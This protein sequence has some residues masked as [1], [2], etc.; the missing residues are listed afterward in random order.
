MGGEVKTDTNEE[1]KALETEIQLRG[2]GMELK[3][4][5]QWRLADQ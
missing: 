1:F 3:G 4:K 2:Q 5:L